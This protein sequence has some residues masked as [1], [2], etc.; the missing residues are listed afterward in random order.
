MGKALAILKNRALA[1]GWMG[2]VETWRRQSAKRKAIGMAVGRMTG[3]AAAL[4]V[5]SARA[6]HLAKRT[7]ER[8]ELERRR[9][10]EKRHA[11]DA[12]RKQA[13]ASV[14]IV[15]EELAN[16]DAQLYVLEMFHV[17]SSNAQALEAARLEAAE[18]RKQ[19][20]TLQ[21]QLH[22]AQ[23]AA[24]TAQP[25]PSREGRK[26]PSEKKAPEKRPLTTFDPIADKLARPTAASAA[27][28]GQEAPKSTKTNRLPDSPQLNKFPV[29]SASASAKS[30][31][32][33]RLS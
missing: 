28:T 24:A 17:A 20:E 18:L 4:R 19:L 21:A 30:P 16:A 8:S 7:G 29:R 31:R 6:R 23:L 32:G 14:S 26:S 12:R 22:A 11:A 5:W 10:V 3:V 2:W 9:E 15:L 1:R 33:G 27:A 13:D 25:P